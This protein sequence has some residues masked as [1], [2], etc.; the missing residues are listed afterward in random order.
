[1]VIMTNFATRYADPAAVPTL[2]FGD[3]LYAQCPI[4][5]LAE[6]TRTHHWPKESKVRMAARLREQ[7]KPGY[8]REAREKHKRL[9]AARWIEVVDPERN[10]E[11]EAI[12][13]SPPASGGGS[14]SKATA[15]GYKGGDTMCVF[16]DW[17]E[18][19]VT[20][21][22]GES[23]GGANLWLPTLQITV[24]YKRAFDFKDPVMRCG[25]F[26]SGRFVEHG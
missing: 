9:L 12:P 26:S 13:Q 25:I 1:M 14:S 8:R 3:P 2:K 16:A 4:P 24:E 5:P 19:S 21:L 10:N 6:S 7:L 20:L 15:G 17:G 11:L 23:A 22:P 18:N